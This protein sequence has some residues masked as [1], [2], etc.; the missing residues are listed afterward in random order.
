MHD[1]SG[2]GTTDLA[3]LIELAAQAA[4]D[5]EALVGSSRRWTWA[6]A[7]SAAV[8]VST[9]LRQLDVR[10]GDHVAIHR[11]KTAESLLAVWGV[12]LAGA[13]VVPIDAQLA[14]DITAG[15]FERADVVAAIVDPR[16]RSRVPAGLAVIDAAA[17]VAAAPSSAVADDRVSRSPGDTAYL[18][19][20]SGSTGV[21]KA[22]V[23][24]HASALAYAQLVVDTY[25]LG[26]TDRVAG[27][28]PLHFDMS[29]LELYAAP[30]ARAAIVVMDEA[31]MRFPASFADRSAKERVSVW[32]T[33]PFFLQ[34]LS[35]RGALDRHDLSSLR[36]LLYGGEPYSPA[37]LAT[38]LDALP[39][40]L[41][42]S[43]VYGPAEVNQC[44]VWN[45]RPAD[46]DVSRPDVPLGVPWSGARV[47]IVDDDGSPVDPGVAGELVVAATTAM[48]GYWKQPELTAAT[49][50]E[51]PELGPGIWYSTGDLVET[52]DGLLHYLGRR[53]HQV[54]IRG[55]RIELDGV[56]AV[57]G[58][59]PGVLHVVAGPTP[60]GDGIVAVVVAADDGFDD[61]ELIAFARAHLHPAAVPTRLIRHRDLPRTGSG[62]IDRR[63]VRHELL[64]HERLETEAIQET[65]A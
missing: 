14:P 27:M 21:P 37:A 65:P 41:S 38:L 7:Y 11:A 56:E 32:Y 58:N 34:Q 49:F 26:P 23:H 22:I 50:F 10:P 24:T 60:A 19:F 8:Q 20:T 30:A 6:E 31:L 51:R 48:S 53:D 13:V 15:M 16:T 1:R 46:L 43:N 47:A 62:K 4:P 42:V 54:K 9:E 61:G 28:S 25:G 64:R 29:T 59:G 52:R 36:W 35:A 18:I 44:T 5:S 57:L 17:T 55:T 2:A 40:H 33:V 12:L 39:T 63:R 3:S 45:F